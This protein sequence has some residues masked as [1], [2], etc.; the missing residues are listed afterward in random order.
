[1]GSAPDIFIS[2]LDGT[3]FQSG[4]IQITEEDLKAVRYWKETGR[5]FWVATGRGKDARQYLKAFGIEP[6]VL[7]CSAGA[8]FVIGEREAEYCGRIV[9][10]TALRIFDYLDGHFPELDYMLDI[11]SG[12][13]HYVQNHAGLFEKRFVRQD[14]LQKSPRDYAENPEGDLLRIFC[15]GPA[16]EYVNRAGAE[17]EKVFSGLVKCYHTDKMCIDIMPAE[18][19]KWNAVEKVLK[20]RSCDAKKTAAIGDEEADILMLKNCGTGFA[21]EHAAPE[22]QKAADYIVPSVYTAIKML[23]SEEKDRADA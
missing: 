23:L 1:M 6:D 9:P 22:T 7:V 14:K 11:T 3:L 18:C 5:E 15:L 4:T 19:N 12:K 16:D 20:I 2:D 13:F 17:I 10:D 21:M 8:G